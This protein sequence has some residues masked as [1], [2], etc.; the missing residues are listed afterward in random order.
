MFKKTGTA[1]LLAV[2]LL[3]VLPGC[4]G[5]VTQQ[6]Y[7]SLSARLQEA[8]TQAEKLETDLAG[9]EQQNHETAAGLEAARAQVAALE[10]QVAA[11]QGQIPSILEQHIQF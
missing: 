3:A 2:L 10:S 5:G 8:Q 9:L 6:Q 11:L 7:D 1:L 4:A